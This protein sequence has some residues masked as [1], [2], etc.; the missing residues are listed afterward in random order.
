MQLNGR[1]TAFLVVALIIACVAWWAVSLRPVYTH[2]HDGDDSH[3][4][5]HVHDGVASHDHTHVGL[6]G[7]VSHS[8][9]H[10]HEHVH[11]PLGIEFETAGMTEIGHLHQ[12]DSRTVYWVSVKVNVDDRTICVEFWT[13]GLGGLEKAVCDQNFLSGSIVVAGANKCELSLVKES[14]ALVGKVPADVVILPNMHLGIDSISMNDNRFPGFHATI[15]LNH[16]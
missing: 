14:D 11:E 3:S 4:H 15:Q 8:H 2:S 12:G 1:S 6:I 16:D 10:V 9:P 5:W 7:T 13:N